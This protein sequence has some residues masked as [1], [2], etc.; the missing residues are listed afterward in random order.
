MRTPTYTATDQLWF[1]GILWETEIGYIYHPAEADTGAGEELEITEVWIGGYYPEGYG[2]T[3]VP[4]NI[5][6]R[7]G[8]LSDEEYAECELAVRAF[9]R[10]E[11]RRDFDDHYGYED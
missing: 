5:K 7:V 9:M 6:S 4:L 1:F 10:K 2:K 11:S 8:E 3:Y